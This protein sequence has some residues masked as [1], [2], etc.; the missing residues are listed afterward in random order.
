V[1]VLR[2][3]QNPNESICKEREISRCN[4]FRRGETKAG[5]MCADGILSP[6]GRLG[7]VVRVEWLAVAVARHFCHREKCEMV[8]AFGEAF[9]RNFAFG[10]EKI[11]SAEDSS[12]SA[13]WPRS[14]S[15]SHN[16]SKRHVFVCL[17]GMETDERER[18]RER[19]G[20]YSCSSHKQTA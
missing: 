5:T 2:R 1:W 4:V 19:D 10:E 17:L 14:P 11:S 6:L 8:F 20:I 9:P 15:P 13:S 7:S 12:F 3:L 18:E 16:T